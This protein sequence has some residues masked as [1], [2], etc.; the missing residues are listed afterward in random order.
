MGNNTYPRSIEECKTL[1]LLGQKLLTE[2]SSK[3]RARI[4][5]VNSSVARNGF[6][7]LD[8]LI[9]QKGQFF[10]QK[11]KEKRKNVDDDHKTLVMGQDM[12]NPSVS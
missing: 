8:R 6:R 9:H 7:D 4:I 10:T 3:W 11:K 2:S 12:V 5:R 1:C